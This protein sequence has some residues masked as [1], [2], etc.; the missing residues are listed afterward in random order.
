MKKEQVTA[1]TH[2]SPRAV[3]AAIGAAIR[4]RK[5][6]QPI[7]DTVKIRQKSI[8][9]TPVEKLT[10]A[11][12]VILAGTHGMCEINTLLRSDVAL[13]SCFGRKACA[14]QSV[15]QETLSACDAANVKQMQEA[16][17]RIFCQ[18]SRSFKH[19]YKEFWQVL[20]ADITGL[21]CGGKSQKANK[22][23]FSREG[24]RHGRQMGR[25]IASL[26]EEVVVDNLYPGNVQLLVSLR[27]MIR[28]AEDVLDLD[29]AK[30]KR[31]IVR[32][33]AGGG[34]LDE[35]NWLL[36]RD[37]QVHCKDFSSVRAR[38]LAETVTRWVVD[39]KSP[40]RELGWVE[41]PCDEYVYRVKRLAMRFR[42]KNKQWSYAVLISTLEAF[43]VLQLTGQ[44]VDKVSDEEAVMSAYAAFYDAR[45]GTVE[46][47]IKEDKQ[48]LGIS[49]RSRLCQMLWKLFSA[50]P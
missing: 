34:S 29:E 7:A 19:S 17:K 43:D 25:V 27:S 35:V 14:E 41:T 12:I 36:S 5:L 50:Y 42:K 39:K 15:V 24:I 22:G 6:L 4:S 31:T 30:R 47:E 32:M 2:Y 21:P 20:D 37:Y 28:A 18:H 3:L 45:S 23:Y 40:T 13:Q 16:L 8:K 11:L 33:D 46:I 49:K 9:H 10:D 1:N 48:S 44:P 26:Y 38:A